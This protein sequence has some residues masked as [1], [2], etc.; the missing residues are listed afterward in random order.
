MVHTFFRTTPLDLVRCGLLVALLSLPVVGPVAAHAQESGATTVSL[1][2][3]QTPPEGET[4][5]TVMLANIPDQQVRVLKTQIEFHDRELIYITARTSFAADVAGA[6]LDVM[7]QNAKQAETSPGESLSGSVLREGKSR[8]LL[9]ITARK[10][11]PNGPLVELRFRVAP[12]FD[13]QTAKPAPAGAA[14]TTPAPQP[15]APT[16]AATPPEAEAV[17]QVVLIKV[18]HQSAAWSPDGAKLEKL[19]AEPGEIRVT[20]AKKDRVPIVFGCFFYM[21]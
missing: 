21:H 1:A 3:P 8:V 12:E 16:E 7:T 10:P 2:S 18:D 14:T 17:P 15:T 9:T 5:I 19:V 11:L 13:E 6:K 4:F 20:S